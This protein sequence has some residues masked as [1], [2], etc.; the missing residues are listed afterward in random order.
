VTSFG[1]LPPILPAAAPAAEPGEE[2]VL[3]GALAAAAVGAATAYALEQQRKRREEEA[4]Q[5]AEAQA[6]AARRN[7]AE[8]AR[9]VQNWLSGRSQLNNWL[10]ALEEQGADQQTIERLKE[11][12][13]RQGIGAAIAQAEKQHAYIKLEHAREKARN[14]SEAEASMAQVRPPENLSE[15]FLGNTNPDESILPEKAIP[16]HKSY[17]GLIP[18]GRFCVLTSTPQEVKWGWKIPTDYWGAGWSTAIYFGEHGSIPS[19]TIG[20]VLPLE[21]GGGYV[22]Y[23]TPAIPKG[24]LRT[25]GRI[26]TVTN[27]FFGM[28]GYGLTVGP[29]LVDNI[30]NDAPQTKID[31]DLLVDS[32]GFVI[33]EIGGL[34]VTNAFQNPLYGFIADLGLGF[35]YDGL[36]EGSNVREVIQYRFEHPICPTLPA[37]AYYPP[38]PTAT[39]LSS[40]TVSNPSPPAWL[41]PATPT[42]APVLIQPTYSPTPAPTST[43]H[44]MITPVLTPTATIHQPTIQSMNSYPAIWQFPGTPT[45]TPT[46]PPTE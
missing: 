38:T 46:T 22:K 11:Q 39:N 25:T 42:Q 20:V 31:A 3:W 10:A 9:K 37:S 15:T 33:P 44:Q 19:K 14:L 36:I 21:L 5:A 45:A 2:G 17:L 35:L 40:P 30:N 7:A 28:V 24:I 1:S 12:A 23:Q 41:F 34:L 32:L 6:E 13:N 43:P 26:G 16:A 4:R 27:L 29:N 8:E 18:T